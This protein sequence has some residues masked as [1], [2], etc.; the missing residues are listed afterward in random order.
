MKTI[1]GLVAV[2][3]LSLGSQACASG[4]LAQLSVYDRTES[5]ELPLH[6]HEGRAYVV[7]RPGNEYRLALRNRSGE[8]VLAVVSVDGVNVITGET[9]SPQQSGYVLTPGRK[10]GIQGWRKSLGETAA[11]YFTPLPDSYAARTGRPDHVGVLGVALY[12]KKT[13]DPAPI[14]HIGPQSRSEAS[15]SAVGGAAGA[16]GVPEA[17]EPVAR[18][19]AKTQ[20]NA[21][22]LGTGHGRRETSRA[23]Y[24]SFERASSAPAQMLT[25]YY[26]SHRNLVARGVIRAPVAPAPQPFPGFAP[27]PVLGFAP[28]RCAGFAP[29]PRGCRGNPAQS[30][31]SAAGLH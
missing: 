15:D 31:A 25:I 23:R 22:R 28:E 14:G 5:R 21:S 7:G 27:D 18:E 12:R 26:D 13:A 2:F 11:F 29:S 17:S 8:E 30:C 3:V 6:W 9:A 4:T 10:L 1:K 16:A 20:Q 19:S 24:V